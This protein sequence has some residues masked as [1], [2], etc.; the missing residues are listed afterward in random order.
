MTVASIGMIPRKELRGQTVLVR[1]DAEDETKLNDSLPT[2]AFA[3]ECGARLVVATHGGP[4]RSRHPIDAVAAWLG[5]FTGRP[6]N[7]LEDWKG[8]AGLRAVNRLD[9]GEI[10]VLENLAFV[11]GEEIA[12]DELADA[13]GRLSDIYCNDAFA[14]SHEVRASTVGAAKRASRALGGIAFG[15]ELNMLELMLARRTPPILAIFGGA[16]SKDKMLLA[17]EIARR[18]ERTLIAGQMAFP[19]MIARGLIAQRPAVTPEMII[20]AERMMAEA[21][22]SKRELNTPSDFTV[23]DRKTFERLSRGEPIAPAP[24]VQNVGQDTI[25][26]EQ[27]ICDVGAATRWAWS[28]YFGRARTIFWHGPLGVCE[29][30][31]FCAGTRFLATQLAERTWP[32]VHRK[33]VCGTSLVTALRRIGFPLQTLRHLTH[34]GRSA[35]HYFA[36]RPLPAVDVLGQER[37][38][39]PEQ[40]N[41]VLI[42]LNGTERDISSL[43]AAAGIVARHS[44]ITLLLVYAG[45]DEERYPDVIE[46]LSAAEKLERRIVSEH[47][48]ARANAILAEGG[49]AAARQMAVQGRPTTMILRYAQRLGADLIVLAAEG[50]FTAVGARRVLNRAPC[51]ALVARP[52]AQILERTYP[53]PAAI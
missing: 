47:I 12:D 30:D 25:A 38:K 31:L 18:A 34:A 16:L 46:M 42:P 51:A 22:D 21:R 26:P 17:E 4:W 23:A 41:R 39:A 49:L 19:F 36:G 45:P 33:V 29:I 52:R 7:K 20:I 9:E 13:L 35:L 40:P 27:I 50:T 2:L 24:P 48:F 53:Y 44:E 3:A 11:D 14:L 15:Y 8:E 32:T 10:L 43:S 37:E 28:D 5:E 6:V 1:V